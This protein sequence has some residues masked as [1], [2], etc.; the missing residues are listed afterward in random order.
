MNIYKS[1][2]LLFVLVIL[3][4]T[5]VAGA[6]D[7]QR[8]HPRDLKYPP[9]S[10]KT[11]EV[12][13][14]N[15]D[16]GLSGFLVEDHEIPV[17][18]VTLL[19]KTYFP[20]QAKYGLNDMAQWAIRNGGSA[21]WPAEKLN[22]ELEFL[23][24][25]VEVFGGDLST[26]VTLNCLKKDLNQVLGIFA[27]LVQNP[28]FP[29]EKVEMRRKTM[30]EEIRRRND[31]PRAVANREF[32]KLI[33][34]GHP[35]GWQTSDSSVQAISREDLVEFH[36]RYFL[37][38]NAILG[39]SGDIT[40]DDIASAFGRVFAQW[41]PGEVTIPNVPEMAAPVDANYNYAYK[42]ISQAYMVI[43]HQG[44]NI[45]NPDRC[46]I[47][48]M[49]YI[50]GG[51]SFTSWITE[52]VRSDAGLAYSCGS[53]YSADPFAKGTF[54]AFAQTKAADY[55]RA[56]QLILQQIDR[57]INDGPNQ[58]ELKKAVDSFLNSQVFDYESKAQ[59]VQRMVNLRFQGRP[60]DSPE[61]DMAIYAKLIVDDI[62]LVA[63]KYLHPDKFTVMVV[64]DEKQFDRPLSDFGSVKVI[65]LD[66]VKEK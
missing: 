11:P 54:N 20:D 49:N 16:N 34:Q 41:K 61:K 31:Q 57:M 37:P 59:V 64:G 27:D 24:A 62:R 19:F 30:L 43:G 28:A 40:K 4:L 17:V 6:K 22:D 38:N 60:L 29:E 50:L 44:I 9:L 46:A 66:E 63:K 35:Y 1:K 42:D 39:I 65:K 56:L 10:I 52:K 12:I 48:V 14:L 51:G 7:F 5:S 2:I 32:S 21:Q 45:N 26:M 8:P 47:N 13:E 55:S 15:L 25:S 23:A 36:T 58:E 3:C 18:N 33:Y 53:R